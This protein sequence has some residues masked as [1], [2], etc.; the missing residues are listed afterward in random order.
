LGFYSIES[1]DCSAYEHATIVH[2]LNLPIP[3]TLKNK[4]TYIYD[5]GTTEHCFHTP[6]VFQNI[7]DMLQVGGVICSIVPN[8][9]QSGHGLYQFSPEF[10][11]SVFAEKYG[12]KVLEMYIAVSKSDRSTWIDVNWVK[13]AQLGRQQAKFDTNE[14]VFVI[15]VAEKIN[16][17][18]YTLNSDPPNQYS[19]EHIDWKTTHS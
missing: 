6:Q 3:E 7:I 1:I 18:E 12:M 9:N 14:E 15:T 2:N 4:Y 8:N 5:G 10:F 11:L 19:Y 16:V 13:T 17:S